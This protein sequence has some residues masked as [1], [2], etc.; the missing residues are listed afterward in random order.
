MT[1]VSH[2]ETSSV[3]SCWV[4]GVSALDSLSLL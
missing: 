1:R 4:I 2:C 3:G